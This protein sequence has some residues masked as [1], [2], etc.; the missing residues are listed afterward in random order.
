MFENRRIIVFDFKIECYSEK[1]S[2]FKQTKS[3][4]DFNLKLLHLIV[5]VIILMSLWESNDFN[6]GNDLL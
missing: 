2:F 1:F 6:K 4:K 3:T 5:I